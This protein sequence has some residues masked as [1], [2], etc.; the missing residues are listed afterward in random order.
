[1]N[2]SGGQ[3]T[4]TATASEGAFQVEDGANNIAYGV[5]FNDQTGTTGEASLTY[6]T[7]SATQSGAN[8]SSSDCSVGGLS[9][10]FHVQMTS[11]NLSAAQPGN[12]TGTLILTVAPQ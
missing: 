10:N 3:Y 6:N 12:Y 11:A 7:A 1:M 4:I 2:D 5:F 8:T 9:A